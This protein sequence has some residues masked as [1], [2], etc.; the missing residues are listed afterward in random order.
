LREK[1]CHFVLY[2]NT[3]WAD[4]AGDE[5]HCPFRFLTGHEHK[6]RLCNAALQWRP[7]FFFPFCIFLFNVFFSP[8]LYFFLPL[9]FPLLFYIFPYTNITN[10]T[11]YNFWR[12][13]TL[14][15]HVYHFTGF[16]NFNVLFLSTSF[17]THI[18][19]FNNKEFPSR[20]MK[21]SFLL[22]IFLVPLIPYFYLYRVLVKK[23]KGK[24]PLGTTSRR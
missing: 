10:A 15:R 8:S 3:E 9:Q 20:L 6:K 14:G 7:L 12:F 23:H 16:F 1:T 5:P 19:I 24:T 13:L 21:P 4:L 17:H 11:V 22:H 18:V 2:G